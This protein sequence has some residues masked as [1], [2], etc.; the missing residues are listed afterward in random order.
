VRLRIHSAAKMPVKDSKQAQSG[1]ILSVRD[2]IML[3]QCGQG[4]VLGVRKVQKPGGRVLL[5]SEF[6]HNLELA[7]RRLG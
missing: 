4:S 2:G 1:S 6:A 7:G 3:V 5:M